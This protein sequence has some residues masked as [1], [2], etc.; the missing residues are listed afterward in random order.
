[1][2]KQSKSISKVTWAHAFRDIVIKAMDRGQLLPIFFFF[3]C[4]ILVSKVPE[5]K[6]YDLAIIIV[7]G[8]KDASLLG[9]LGMIALAIF[10][11][12]HAQS[13]R[14]KH[15]AEY[16]RI[17]TEKSSLQQRLNTKSPFISSDNR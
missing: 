7:D 5:E 13:M 6:A 12:I 4:L 10:W 1:M 9:W 16:K 11:A 3:S 17:G 2:A 8:F 14:R 15:S